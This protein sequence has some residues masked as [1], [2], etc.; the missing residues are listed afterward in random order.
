MSDLHNHKV[1]GD[2]N[3][4]TEIYYVVQ[5]NTKAYGWK[6]N[7]AAGEFIDIRKAKRAVVNARKG[8][9]SWGTDPKNVRLAVF[10]RT[11]TRQVIDF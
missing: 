5:V 9:A 11:I 8:N 2:E 10:T 4:T 7:T 3:T 1:I 6:T